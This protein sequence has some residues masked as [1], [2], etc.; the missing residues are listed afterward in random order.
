MLIGGLIIARR[1]FFADPKSRVSAQWLGYF[2]YA[3]TYSGEHVN[4][5]EHLLQFI[6][7]PIISSREET[8]F[9]YV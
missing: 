3:R 7:R 4:R 1:N 2:V 5:N 6:I 9:V 8:K